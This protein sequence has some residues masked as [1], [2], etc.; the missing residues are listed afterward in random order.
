[1]TA[2]EDKAGQLLGLLFA[3]GQQNIETITASTAAAPS[4]P[5]IASISV[6]TLTGNAAITAPTPGAAG[7]KKVLYLVQGSG[8]SHVPTWIGATVNWQKGSAPVL[9]TPATSVDTVTLISLDG[10]TWEGT[11]ALTPSAAYTK[12]FSTAGRTI[13]AATATAVTQTSSDTG[14]TLTNPYGYT[15][16][17]ELEYLVTDLANLTAAVN[18]L[19]ADNLNLRELIVAI[20]EDTEQRGIL[21]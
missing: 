12:T 17:A 3:L 19:I 14:I 1:M 20:V 21:G 8:G 18:D 11:F 2:T 6:I 10:S 13:A 9:S 5:D 7:Q 4:T 16:A 15:T